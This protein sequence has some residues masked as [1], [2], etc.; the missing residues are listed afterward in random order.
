MLELQELLVKGGYINP[1]EALIG[2]KESIEDRMERASNI[3]YDFVTNNTPE[4]MSPQ[5][6]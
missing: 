4:F 5:Y 2:A 3:F 1:E 6:D